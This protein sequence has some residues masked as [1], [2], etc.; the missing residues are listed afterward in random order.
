MAEAHILAANSLLQNGAAVGQAYFISDGE[1]VN[2]FEFMRPLVEGLG[3]S[4]P[5]ITLP[6]TL[7]YAMAWLIEYIHLFVGR[8]YNFQP[9]LTRAEV[10]K[11]GITHYF[12]ITKAQ[13]ELGYEPKVKPA[14]GMA[15]LVESFVEKEKQLKLKNARNSAGDP[16][17]TLIF[18]T[19]AVFGALL[20]ILFTFVIYPELQKTK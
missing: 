16:M 20:A 17:N 1:P 2:N 19:C 12:K 11:T 10:N 6:Y 4:Y 18:V 15:R 9:L 8:V 7:V 13:R 5:T 14:E 3:Y